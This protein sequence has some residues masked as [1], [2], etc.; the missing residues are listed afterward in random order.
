MSEPSFTDTVTLT[1]SQD[2]FLKKEADKLNSEVEKLLE[3]TRSREKY[4]LTII[5]GVAVW[6][7]T[8]LSDTS[9]G[10]LKAVSCIP[11]VT[12][13]I[14]GISVK[15][16]YDNIKWIGIYLR[17]IEDYFLGNAKDQND[18]LWGWE[19]YFDSENKKSKFVNVTWG[20]WILQVL[21]AIALFILVSYKDNLIA[22]PQTHKS[23]NAQQ[24][25]LQKQGW[26]SKRQLCAGFS[27]GSGLTFN[28][29]L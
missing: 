26:T 23:T 28:F 19:K 8:H 21:L 1:P 16:L 22:K 24:R 2:D 9:I 7:F 17:R 14:Y 11:L 15:Y 13:L 10:L 6:V 5:A 20:S 25:Y 12:T 4:S 29:Q 3:E 27:S 18:N